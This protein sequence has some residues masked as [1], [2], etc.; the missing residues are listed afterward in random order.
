VPADEIQPQPAVPQE[1]A[2]RRDGSDGAV[3]SRQRLATIRFSYT[4]NNL[5][6]PLNEMTTIEIVNEGT[7]I[8]HKLTPGGEVGTTASRARPGLSQAANRYAPA[9]DTAARPSLRPEGAMDRIERMTSS[10]EYD[11]SALSS[12]LRMK[13]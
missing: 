5:K 2:R 3:Y 4:P 13:L 6:V 8:H 7:P 12:M 9:A 10:E 11:P 1:V